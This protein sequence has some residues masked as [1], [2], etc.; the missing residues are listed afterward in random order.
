MNSFLIEGL[1]NIPVAHIFVD[2]A[3]KNAPDNAELVLR[4]KRKRRFTV[5]AND[6]LVTEGNRSAQKPAF[7]RA[8]HLATDRI[9]RKTF[10]IEIGVKLKYWPQDFINVIPLEVLFDVKDIHSGFSQKVEVITDF[11]IVSTAETCDI[12]DNNKIKRFWFALR[13]PNQLLKL[14]SIL[15]KGAGD[16]VIGVPAGKLKPFPVR[17]RKNF[18]FLIFEGLLLLV[19]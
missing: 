14:T 18:S 19:C 2:V 16:S 15:R 10:K 8:C 17:K 1:R 12:I 4:I 3:V 6:P 7:S 11:G 13:R 9:P 5:L